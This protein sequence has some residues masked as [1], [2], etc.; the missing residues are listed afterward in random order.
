[1]IEPGLML[2]AAREGKIEFF[3]ENIHRVSNIDVGDEVPIQI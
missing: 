3:R 1:M 2:E